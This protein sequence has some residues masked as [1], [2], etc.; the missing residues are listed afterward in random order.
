MKRFLFAILFLAAPLYAQ[1]TAITNVRLFDGT[2][3]IPHATVVI[4]GTRIVAAGAK[5]AVPAGAAVGG[6][7]GENVMPGVVDLHAHVHSDALER[8][9]RLW[10]TA[11]NEIVTSLP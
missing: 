5:V 9:R 10:G 2:N 4:D 7:S 6:G 8:A 1:H 11:E 3:V